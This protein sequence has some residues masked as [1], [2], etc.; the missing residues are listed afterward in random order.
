MYS[1]LCKCKNGTIT[2]HKMIYV[3]IFTTVQ[4]TDMQATMMPV[5]PKSQL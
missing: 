1:T 5:D 2:K 3:T 4:S